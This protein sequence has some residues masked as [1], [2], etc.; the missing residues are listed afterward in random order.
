MPLPPE[1]PITEEDWNLTPPAVQAVVIALWQQVQ[2]LQAQVSALQ[3][4]VA[5]LREEVGRNSQ[6]SSQP[7]SSDAPSARPRPKRAPSGR[8]PGGQKGHTGHG[9]K[10]VPVEQ[11]KHVIDLK[12]TGCGQCGALLMG[13]DAQPVRRQ[14]RELPRVEPEV[15]EYRQHTLTC[16]A[17]GA[18]TQ[19]EFPAEMPSGSFGPRVQ[20]TVGY[21]TGRIGVSQRD[22]EEVM[23]T[24]FHTDISLGSIPAQE[25]QV[26]AAL[27]EP[28]RAVQTY[29]QQQPIQNV[30]ETS[31]REKTKRAWLW[32]NTTP[33]VT[34]FLVLATRGAE[35]AQ[36]ILGTVV[37]SIIGS[38][39]WS[40]Y[41]WLDPHQR[42]LCWAHLKRDFQA[43]V[44]RGGESGRIGRA[45][46]EQV[47]KMF[48]LWH[49]VRDGTLSRTDFQTAMQPIQARVGDLLCEG[50]ALACDQT[51]RTCENILKLE[52]AL[53]TFVRVEGV[54]PTNNS[55]ERGLR[56][57]VLWRRRSFGTQSEE[58]SHFVE[59]VLT[60]V[61]TLRQQKRDV[62][63]YLTQACAAAMRGD[64]AP[65]LLPDAS[66]IKSGA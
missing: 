18:P 34:L 52:V 22:V 28:V 38:D 10:L 51:R 16:L 60:T 54:E 27:A 11:V 46:L 50:A 26:S 58:G 59:R 66:I 37:K 48:G 15:T 49:R 17:C 31:W 64:K 47:E 39:R 2:A 20:A 1:L 53:W 4:E 14:V 12:P 57:A 30:D 7:P 45:L 25:D 42:Q 55:A 35:G 24:V 6:N 13:E 9:R 43:L 56:R 62:L 29:V 61:T 65:S 3:A 32:I 36:R 63:D 44:E 5:Q 23:Q 8:K 21:L 40:G 41:T 19:A 33:W